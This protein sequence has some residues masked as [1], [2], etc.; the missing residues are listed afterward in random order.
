[1]NSFSFDKFHEKKNE[2]WVIH[3]LRTV[4]VFKHLTEGALS[5][6]W[7]VKTIMV[8]LNSS[9]KLQRGTKTLFFL[10]LCLETVLE[11]DKT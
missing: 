9:Q 6:I 5:L 8:D 3:V 11:T 2:I 1:M 4:S 10:I 7:N